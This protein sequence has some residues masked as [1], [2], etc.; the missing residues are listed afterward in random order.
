[1]TSRRIGANYPF[2]LFA[3]AL[4]A[5]GLAAAGLFY[6][7]VA[8]DPAQVIGALLHPG[9]TDLAATI[10]WEIR[11]P[12]VLIGICVGAGLGVAGAMLQMLF[13]NALVDPY[14]SGVSA[15]AALAAVAALSL[16]ASFAMIP[17]YAFAGGIACA[18]VVAFV[19]ASGGADGNLRLVLAGV[20]ISALC[21]AIVTLVLLAAG[22]AGGRSV[23][24]WLAG[25]IGGRGWPELSWVAIYLA[26][27]FAAS[28]FA[29]RDLNALRLGTVAAAGFG[30]NVDAARLRVLAIA[31]LIT[32]A[33]VAVSGVVGFVGLMV[34]H[35]M[36]RL[37]GGDARRLLPACAAGGACIVLLADALAR[38][39]AAPA[40][41]PLGVVLAFAG[42]PFFLIVA[43][44]PVEI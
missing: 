36:R 24:G 11:L 44:R 8:L 12:R 23:I 15:G 5:L 13:R 20:A 21:A 34:P 25:G 33:C 1:M 16:S 31:A 9:R 40:E 27:G 42:V 3:L 43:R 6:G 41:V 19:G 39:I 28:V 29:L 38:T 7:P 30:L 32:A 4:F 10:V 2:R 26:V 22:E 14:I 18:I 35:T 37:V 17:A